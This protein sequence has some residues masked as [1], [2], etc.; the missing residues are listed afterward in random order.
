MPFGAYRDKPEQQRN[1]MIYCLSWKAHHSQKT[2]IKE[3]YTS[4]KAV[5]ERQKDLIESQLKIAE[6][7]KNSHA[8]EILC[9]AT[10]S[11]DLLKGVGNNSLYASLYSEEALCMTVRKIRTPKNKEEWSALIQFEVSLN[12]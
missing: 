10:S 9:N 11:E 3:Y 1:K 7:W 12:Q 8:Y 4:L 6:S 2:I 5:E